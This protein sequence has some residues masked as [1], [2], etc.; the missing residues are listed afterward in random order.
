MVAYNSELPPV[1]Y[2]LHVG[3]IVEIRTPS[4]IY[5]I[6]RWN[7]KLKL[8][9][10]RDPNKEFD[11][12]P[13]KAEMFVRI[14]TVSPKNRQLFAIRALL[15]HRVGPTSFDDLL[16]IDGNPI[17]CTSFSEAAEKHGLLE[18][19]EIYINTM[20]DACAEKMN[21]RRLQHF[22][23]MLLY[24]CHPTKSQE[25]FTKF[26][27]EM[28]PPRVNAG[29]RD[30]EQRKIEVLKNLEYFFRCMGTSCRYIYK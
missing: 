19:D 4:N 12:D 21:L 5:I 20:Q 30:Y 3:Y 13:E 14:Y 27:D 15:L 25:L 17:P 24:H 7:K 10:R 28:K 22:F 6:F 2:I 8:W 23:A 18:S 1:S 11:P 9:L 29:P 26:L 16:K